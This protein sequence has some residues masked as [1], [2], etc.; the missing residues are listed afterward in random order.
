MIGLTGHNRACSRAAFP[1]GSTIADRAV[2][3]HKRNTLGTW[4]AMYVHPRKGRYARVRVRRIRRTP[5]RPATF[6]GRRPSR[7]CPR[8]RRDSHR[9]RHHRTLRRRLCPLLLSAYTQQNDEIFCINAMLY[10]FTRNQI[11]YNIF[12]VLIFL[13]T[14]LLSSRNLCL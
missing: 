12:T 10:S 13:Y 9:R 14:S 11:I 1:S 8:D 6:P 5:L 3:W 4:S 7:W 2:A